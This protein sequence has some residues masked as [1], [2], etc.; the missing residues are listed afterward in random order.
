MQRSMRVFHHT[1]ES[2]GTI[3]FFLDASP[4]TVLLKNLGD[5][6]IF[7]SWGK[8]ISQTDYSELPGNSAELYE[9]DL[10]RR[11]PLFTTIEATG[12]THVELRIIDD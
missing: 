12:A 10:P 9:Y 2:S 6:T 8:T 11:E 3:T 5:N 1:F 7:F 4:H